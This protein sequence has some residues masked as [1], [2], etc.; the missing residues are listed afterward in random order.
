M[1]VPQI[2]NLFLS[3][4]SNST[5]DIKVSQT[6]SDLS[7]RFNVRVIATEHSFH[8]FD[9][10]IFSRPFISISTTLQHSQHHDPQI[11]SN[12]SK[13]LPF[14]MKASDNSSDNP[15]L[16]TDADEWNSW[17]KRSDP[18]I[19]I[20]LRNWADILIVAPLDA[21]TLAKIACGISDNLL[22]CVLRAW[23]LDPLEESSDLSMIIKL[24]IF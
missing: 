9:S 11:S 7:V 3:Y 6:L 8:F 10:S 5:S 15:I 13:N 24:C 19:H 16:F 18:V 23:Q 2:C 21:N 20:D 22:T 4:N 14:A 17:A 1:K 12:Q